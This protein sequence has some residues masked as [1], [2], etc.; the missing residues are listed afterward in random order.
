MLKLLY[1][2]SLDMC[3]CGIYM[4][5]GVPLSVS[6]PGTLPLS[7]ETRLLT[8][9]ETQSLM[10]IDFPAD[11]PGSAWLCC[12]PSP[13]IISDDVECPCLALYVGHREAK[14][15]PSYLRSTHFTHRAI[16]QVPN[17]YVSIF[18]SIN[19]TYS[20]SACEP[21]GTELM[22]QLKVSSVESVLTFWPQ[23]ILLYILVSL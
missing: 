5:I 14:L 6:C 23:F 19:F 3:A 20:L 22:W 17:F 8:E 12:F 15:R 21:L 9:F 13:F 16:S 18:E 10:E 2:F 7:F 11:P 4:S 1:L